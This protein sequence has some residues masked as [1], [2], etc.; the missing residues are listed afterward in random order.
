M[1]VL[2]RKTVVVVT[3]FSGHEVRPIND[4]F[5]PHDY[6]HPVLSLTVVQVFF[7]FFFFFF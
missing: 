6:I 3:I 2:G 4:L 1:W 5:R 7:F